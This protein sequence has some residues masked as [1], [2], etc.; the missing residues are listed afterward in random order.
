MALGLTLYQ[1]VEKSQQEFDELLY[2]EILF[3]HSWSLEDE[4]ILL[5]LLISW[6]FMQRHTK[7]NIFCFIEMS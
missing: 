2:H 6:L 3:R 4:S 1:L 7:M 5:P